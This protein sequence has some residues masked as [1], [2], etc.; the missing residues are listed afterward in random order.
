M[1]HSD[2][3]GIGYCHRSWLLY[4]WV[5]IPIYKNAEQLQAIDAKANEI[6]DKLRTM[7]ISVKYDNADN[8]RP[9]SSLP[10][11]S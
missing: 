8:K 4:R 2:D 7:G 5:I 3:N 11:M 10:I 9:G 6:A 1:T